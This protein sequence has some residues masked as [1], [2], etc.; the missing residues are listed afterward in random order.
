[1]ENRALLHHGY[2]VEVLCMLET[3]LGSKLFIFM[4]EPGNH[5]VTSV[6][7]GNDKRTTNCN[8]EGLIVKL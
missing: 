5:Q 2:L 7:Q 6:T 4:H 8:S 3:K 1:M